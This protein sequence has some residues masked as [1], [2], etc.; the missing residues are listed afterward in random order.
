MSGQNILFRGAS[1]TRNPKSVLCLAGHLK[2]E[3]SYKVV[4]NIRSWIPGFWGL[5]G[6]WGSGCFWLYLAYLAIWLYYMLYGCTVAR[7]L[8]YGCTVARYLLYGCTVARYL[9]CLDACRLY[10]CTLP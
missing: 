3:M 4:Y 9:D 6:F 10:C 8:L 2:S 7:Y 1:Y 5:D